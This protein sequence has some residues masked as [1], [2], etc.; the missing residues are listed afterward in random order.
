[1]AGYGQFCPVAK[2]MELLDER[3]TMLVVRELL[4]GSRHFN[5]LR[6]GLPRMSPTLLSARLR[7][8]ARAGLVERH[9][10]GRQV[11]YVL[12]PAGEQLRPI[13]E[14]LGQWGL[15][16]V[17]ELGDVDYD[18]HLLMWDLHR[19][20]DLDAVPA[21]RTVLRFTFSD[22]SPGERSW[23]IVIDAGGVDLCRVDPGHPVTATI[24]TD[25]RT[26]TRIWRGE[27][28]WPRSQRSGRLR[29]I[30]PSYVARDL[31][32]WLRKE[33]ITVPARTAS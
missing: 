10:E 14:A 22:V 32:R 21:D 30:G 23:W 4:C 19:N 27:L 6:R 16:W 25:L 24:E 3:W 7:T 9:D 26:L 15:R 28:T 5:A 29:V 18:P 17:P 1:M 11:T 2:A 8:L 20:V 13:V 12:T 33:T 31:P